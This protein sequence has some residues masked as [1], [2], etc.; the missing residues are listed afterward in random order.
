LPSALATFAAR[1]QKQLNVMQNKVT[2]RVEW[3]KER[4]GLV[5]LDGRNSAPHE[6]LTSFIGQCICDAALRGGGNAKE[7]RAL[8]PMC[9]RTADLKWIYD[10]GY[11]VCGVDASEK[12]L[13]SFLHGHGIE[14]LSAP[15]I[16]DEFSL[17]KT[18]DDRLMLFSGDFFLFN[19]NISGC[20]FHLI[21]DRG[22]FVNL[23]VQF[24]EKYINLLR[25]LLAPT[26]RILLTTFMYDTSKWQGPPYP[27]KC[28]DVRNYFSRHFFVNKLKSKN[29]I[30][31]WQQ[32]KW[33]IDWLEESCYML[34]LKFFD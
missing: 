9:G 6:L 33:G 16:S 5:D 22:V 15:S 29:G 13:L 1:A 4:T 30:Q 25:S 23:P 34:S 28:D 19:N 12:A 27:I 31:Q 24:R 10:S 20:Q 2:E 17:Y 21:W 7:F 26:G 18:H 11:S 8:I 14:Y 3:W 32:E